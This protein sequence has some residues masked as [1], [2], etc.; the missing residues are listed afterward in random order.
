MLRFQI[1]EGDRSGIA[2]IDGNFG[3]ELLQ[4]LE[5]EAAEHWIE[6]WLNGQPIKLRA[7]AF[8]LF[9]SKFLA[10]RRSEVPR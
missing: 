8:S 7:I 9:K 1:G 3:V 4:D 6:H 5:R 2:T 10:L